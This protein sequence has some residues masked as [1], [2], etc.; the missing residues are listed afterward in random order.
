MNI[1]MR[2]LEKEGVT[3]KAHFYDELMA[4]A[5]DPNTHVV[6]DRQNEL[7][8]DVFTYAIVVKGT[9]FWLGEFATKE[10]AEQVIHEMG[11]IYES[12]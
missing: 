7:D 12:K 2:Q 11:W 8:Y 5:R 10:E 9:E 6:L 4:Y 3:E 1:L